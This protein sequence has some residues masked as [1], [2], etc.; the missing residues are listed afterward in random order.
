[1]KL[2]IASKY[3]SL[4]MEEKF[5]PML[6]CFKDPS[7]SSTCDNNVSPFRINNQIVSS[8]AQ[9][10]G[11]APMLLAIFALICKYGGMINA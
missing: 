3:R 5:I 2:T 7:S 9:L 1:M 11:A 10:T 8:L 4:N 6:E